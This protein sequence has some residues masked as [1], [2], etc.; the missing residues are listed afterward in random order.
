MKLIQSFHG[1]LNQ[2]FQGKITYQF[3]LPKQLSSLSVLLTYDKEHVSD[4]ESYMETCQTE[5]LSALKDYYKRSISRE[6][7][8][9]LTA[10]M[11]TELQPELY[12]NHTF[13]GSVHMPGTRKELF[14]SKKRVAPGCLKCPPLT[15]AAKIIVNVFQ[16]VEDQTSYHLEIRGE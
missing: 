3:S 13:A 5:L 7:L 11:K 8:C 14:L 6:E 2:G 10:S 15:G 9:R 12:I 16:V 1:S 4:A